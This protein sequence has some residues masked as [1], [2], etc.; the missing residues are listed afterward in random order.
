MRTTHQDVFVMALA[1]FSCVCTV[2]VHGAHFLMINVLITKRWH[3]LAGKLD[4]FFF[5]YFFFCPLLPAGIKQTTVKKIKK[6]RFEWFVVL[7][8]ML[9][10]FKI[11]VGLTY[12]FW[13]QLSLRRMSQGLFSSHPQS[14][15]MTCCTQSTVAWPWGSSHTA[16]LC[17]CIL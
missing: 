10:W 6:K 8:Q 13:W 1:T 17:L 7:T 11:L 2:P 16:D 15:C 5:F 14:P 12:C 4:V 3:R 9:Q